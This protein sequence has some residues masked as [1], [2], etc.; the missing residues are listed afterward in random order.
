MPPWASALLLLVAADAVLLF[1]GLRVRRGQA[2]TAKRYPARLV[3]ID[4]L[5]AVSAHTMAGI[6]AALIMDNFQLAFLFSIVVGLPPAVVFFLVLNEAAELS[7]GELVE[8]GPAKALD[9][10]DEVKRLLKESDIEGAMRVYH[11]RANQ[12]PESPDPLF[13]L[14]FL[15]EQQDRHDEAAATCREILGRF[16]GDDV[17]WAKAAHLLA[18]LLRDHLGDPGGAQRLR[19]AITQRNPD[20]DYGYLLPQKPRPDPE[21]PTPPGDPRSLRDL[22]QARRL[23]KR[24]QTDQALDLFRRFAQD[25]PDE[26]RPLFEA[27]SALE[28]AERYTESAAELQKIVHKF[29]END[30]TWG[31][32]ALRL[33][34][35]QENYF[36]DVEAAR[37]ILKEVLG[38]LMGTQFTQLARE[39]LQALAADSGERH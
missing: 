2:G 35:L 18:P 21:A 36:G 6:L 17:V 39:R 14:E 23:A 5:L 3:V 16:Q 37:A 27:A 7:A 13:G 20:E 4:C 38:R 32:A 24:G 34:T 10:I 30:S 26:P 1:I 31:E 25:H 29:G 11:R 8:G 33:A 28:I 15:F 19:E 22:E 9:H 12:H